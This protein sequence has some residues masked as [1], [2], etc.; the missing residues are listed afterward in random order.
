MVV[1]Y[2]RGNKVMSGF[3]IIYLGM[4]LLMFFSS[5]EPGKISRNEEV[6]KK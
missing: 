4:V 2:L 5:L 6:Y 3:I 1:L